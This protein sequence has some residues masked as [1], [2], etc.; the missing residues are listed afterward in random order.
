MK[1]ESLRNATI[2][3]A[4]ALAS[5]AGA[6]ALL[7]ALA[8]G[9]P[10]AQAASAAKVMLRHTSRGTILVASN[11]HTVYE[12]TRD[13]LRQ[14]SCVSVR[15]CSSAWPPLLTSARPVAGT[16]V[17]S[18]MLST[19]AI[20]G[21]RKQVTYAGHALYL[22]SEDSAPGET[23]YIGAKQFGGFWYGLTS[24]ARAVR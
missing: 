4:A 17:Q 1:T 21:G 15:G 16:G 14:N 24:S 5:A 8:A 3:G 19:I 9:S 6:A 13:R 20:S 18:S 7:P 11:G 2:A 10:H 22:Y 23:G 12:F